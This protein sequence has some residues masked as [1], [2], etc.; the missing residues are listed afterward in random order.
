MKILTLATFSWGSY[1]YVNPKLSHI[2]SLVK[3]LIWSLS[4]CRHTCPAPPS[5]ISPDFLSLTVPLLAHYHMLSLDTKTVK[6][7]LT[8]SPSTL[9]KQIS[10]HEATLLLSST[11]NNSFSDHFSWYDSSAFSLCSYHSPWHHHCPWKS[12]QTHFPIPQTSSYSTSVKQ[13]GWKVQ[14]PISK[15]SPFV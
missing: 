12:V 4:R 2:R 15:T 3:L 11:F 6:V 5:H 10:Q 7:L 1:L 8:F 9:S 14:C 13:C